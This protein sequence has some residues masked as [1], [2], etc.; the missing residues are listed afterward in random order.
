MLADENERTLRQLVPRLLE[1]IPVSG[2]AAHGSLKAV[3]G[4]ATPA[5]KIPNATGIGNSTANHS[6]KC[7]NP[8]N[9]ANR[10]ICWLSK[11]S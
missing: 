1:R 9:A 7:A 5:K 11:P 8:P 2:G 4:S 6:I 3:L 10:A